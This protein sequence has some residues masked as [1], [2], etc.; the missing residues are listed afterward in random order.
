[1]RVLVTGALGQVGSELCELLGA[2]PQH[3][4]LALSHADLDISDRERTLQVTGEWEPEVIINAAAFTNVDACETNLD[5]AFGVNALGPRNV[6][7][8]A[9]M[10]GAHLV[11][12]STDYVFDGTSRSP[13]LEWDPPN[14]LS[15]YGRSK[16]AGEREVVSLQPGAAVVRSS[17]ICG[18]YGPNMVK[19]VLRLARQP[20]QLRFVDDQRG[21]PTFASD[22][23]AML[24][25]LAISRAPGV[26]HVTNQGPT[27]WFGFARDVLTA[28]GEDPARVLPIKTAD[29][30]PPR[31]AP[32]PANSVLDNAALRLLGVPLLVD[33]HDPL[34]RTV[35][36]LLAT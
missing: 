28:A 15:V 8:A 34:E 21:C 22:L 16:L 13:Y 7:E 5:K 23:A 24:V 25:Q 29:L 27:S 26:F 20:G 10:V 32:R 1:M 33:Y 6:A 3:Q 36:Y 12:V 18:R 35:K 17:W 9:Q 19:T 30:D 11:H 2:A 4:L 14:P 31:P